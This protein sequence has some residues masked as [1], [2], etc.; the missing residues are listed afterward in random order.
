MTAVVKPDQNKDLAEKKQDLAPSARFTEAVVKEMAGVGI[1]P[2]EFQKKLAQNYFVK[3]DSQLKDLEQKRVEKPEAY[4]EEIPYGWNTINMPKLAQDVAA[5]TSIGLDPMLKN[6]ISMIPYANK[7][8]KVYDVGFLDG[9]I[10]KEIKVKKFGYDIPDMFV[11]ELVY[12]NDKFELIKKSAENKIENYNFSIPNPFDRGEIIGG[13]YAHIWFNN[14]EKNKV[15]AFSRAQLEKR[16]PK[17]ASAEFWGGVKTKKVKEWID[18]EKTGKKQQIEREV[19][20]VIEGWFD[21][22]MLKTLKRASKDVIAIDSEKINDAYMRIS[23][24]EH[25]FEQIPETNVLHTPIEKEKIKI[26]SEANAETISFEEIVNEAPETPE[27]VENANVLNNVGQELAENEER[28][29]D[30]PNTST[31][32]EQA[33]P[34]TF[35]SDL[36]NKS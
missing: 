1:K 26:E 32:E 24:A 10:G 4:R 11:E 25:E 20:E 31:D 3:L 5:F 21:E 33:P 35:G 34:P 13:F 9:Y 7:K 19:E 14:P 2:T 17:K 8:T 6:H 22:M 16:R 29:T 15:V 27:D 36:F 28:Q 12:T 30:N 18:N 23:N